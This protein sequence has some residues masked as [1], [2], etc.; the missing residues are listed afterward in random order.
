MVLRLSGVARRRLKLSQKELNS[1]SN[2]CSY[3]HVS[4]SFAMSVCTANESLARLNLQVVT[5]A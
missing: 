1:A 2:Y 3:H 5:V 4:N